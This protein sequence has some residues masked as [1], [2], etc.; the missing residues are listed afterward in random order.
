LGVAIGI[1]FSQL[2]DVDAPAKD[3]RQEGAHVGANTDAE[4]EMARRQIPH[5]TT[6]GEWFA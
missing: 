5:V 4:V 3:C 2:D 1:L 6:L